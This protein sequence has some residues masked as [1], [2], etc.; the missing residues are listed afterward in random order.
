M[1]TYYLIRFAIWWNRTTR[2]TIKEQPV[3]HAPQGPRHDDD[4]RLRRESFH[5]LTHDEIVDIQEGR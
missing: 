4:F 3:D 2:P 1:I 5:L